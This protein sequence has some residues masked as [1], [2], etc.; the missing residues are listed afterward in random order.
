MAQN[1]THDQLVQVATNLAGRNLCPM[2]EAFKSWKTL[3][4]PVDMQARKTSAPASF[5][6][7]VCGECGHTLLFLLSYLERYAAKAQAHGNGH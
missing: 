4:T 1:F 5:L 6:T 3:G 2:C 7:L